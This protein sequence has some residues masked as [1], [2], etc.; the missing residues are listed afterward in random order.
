MSLV[1]ELQR[2]NVFRVVATYAVAAWLLVQVTTTLL[3]LFGAPAWIARAI[4]IVLLLGT[5]PMLALAWAFQFTPQGLKTQAEADAAGLSSPVGGPR[6]NVAIGALLVLALGLFALGRYSVEPIAPAID[7]SAHTSGAEN[8]SAATDRPGDVSIAV[9]P[10]VN[11]SADKDNEYF[12]DGLSETLL[13]MLAQVPDLKVVGRT[14][15]FA[16]KGKNEDLRRIGAALSVANVLEGSVQKAGDTVRIT[17]QL[18]SVRDGTHR[19]SKS[20]DRKLEDV[21]RIQDEIAT[22]V[23]GALRLE[24]QPVARERLTLKRTDNVDAYQEYLRGLAL[25]PKRKVS[26]L[27]EAAAHF[28]KAI[29]LD[30]EFARAYV[31]AAD[32]YLLLEGYEGRDS[33]RMARAKRY[34]DRAMHLSPTLG[35]AHASLGLYLQLT[36]DPE[37]VEQVF[38]RA[39][40]LAPSHAS[41]YVW[42]ASQLRGKPERS[43]EALALSEKAAALEPLSPVVQRHLAMSQGAGASRSRSRHPV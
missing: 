30:P 29:Q 12:S 13:N 11:M 42:Y 8:S 3:P 22:E 24:L 20:Y 43:A 34:V 2:R 36:N 5:L 7:A 4:V 18:I 9:L 33:N 31:G 23:V 32:S 37:R 27:R 19:W 26:E 10:F 41:T 16:F 38:K 21:F 28:E 17:A 15:S 25:M 40:E 6:L 35:E 14:S 39:I 1:S